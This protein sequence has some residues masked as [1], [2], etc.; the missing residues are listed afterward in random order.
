MDSPF[1][2]Y[3]SL[4]IHYLVALFCCL[5][6]LIAIFKYYLQNVDMIGMI[7]YTSIAC[8]SI[9]MIFVL[10]FLVVSQ[11]GYLCHRVLFEISFLIGVAT[12]ACG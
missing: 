2:I 7:K 6:G 8:T 10:S 1:F 12:M 3:I 9:W 5:F 4:A 11:A